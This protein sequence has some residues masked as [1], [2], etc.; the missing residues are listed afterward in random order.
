MVG[1][2]FLTDD[3]QVKLLLTTLESSRGTFPGSTA[4][5]EAGYNKLPRADATVNELIRRGRGANV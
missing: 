1:S 3:M 2:S 4:L 5:D